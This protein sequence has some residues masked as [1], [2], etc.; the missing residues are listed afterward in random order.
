MNTETSINN[1]HVILVAHRPDGLPSVA[2]VT[3][4]NGKPRRYSLVDARRRLRQLRE[5][6][7]VMEQVEQMLQGAEA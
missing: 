5:R 7:A 3:P 4:L 6:L 2:F 1:H